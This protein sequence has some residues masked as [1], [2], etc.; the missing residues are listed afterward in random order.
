MQDQFGAQLLYFSNCILQDEEPEPDGQE[1]LT[2][3]RIIEAML[4]SMESGHVVLLKSAS[5]NRRPGTN[6]EIRLPFVEPPPKLNAM[7]PSS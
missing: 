6:Q 5:R 7:V 4:N 1:G 2:D 3:V